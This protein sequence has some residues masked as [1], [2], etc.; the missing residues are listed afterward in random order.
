MALPVITD[1]MRVA[2]RGH[3]VNGHAFANV[4]HFRKSGAITFA[5][6]I[7]I[8]DPKLVNHLT[9][10]VGA[11]E[12]WRNHA[13]TGTTIDDFTYTP[14]DG[15]TATTVIAHAIPGISAG[16]ELP[17]NVAL[18]IT[19]RTALRGRSHRGRVYQAPFVEGENTSLG[20]P[21]SATVANIQTQ[22]NGLLTNLAGTGV[23]LVVA[24]YKLVTATDVAS[25]TVDTR[26][27]TQRRRLKP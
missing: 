7:A 3:L 12:P 5:A 20:N 19:L 18:V 16:D 14:L 25:I 1:T 21:L 9:V 11:G 27:D 2:V 26:W 24:S 8:L 23:S 13:N 17:A 22:W 4:M 15:A 10:A 6:A